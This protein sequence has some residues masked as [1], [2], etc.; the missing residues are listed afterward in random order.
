MNGKLVRKSFGRGSSA[1]ADAVA[2]VEKARTIRRTGEGVLPTTAKRPVLTTV[3]VAVLGDADAITVGKL[4]DEFL[5]YVRAHPEEYR[6]Q[7]NPPKRIAEIKKVFG[8]RNAKKLK[9]PE[10][11]DW[12]DEIQ[13]DREL[14]NA[15]INKMRGSF[16]MIYKHGKRKDLVSVN[17]A[18][19]VP[20]RDV[21]QGIE[22]FLSADEEK[23]LRKVLQRHIDT[24]DPVEHPELR[25]QAIHRLL[26]FEVSLKSGMRRSEQYNLQWGEVDFD[27]RIMR[28][29]KT[30]NGKPRNAFI[31]D[32]VA[33]ALKQ[34]R[35][36]DL[37][38]RDRSGS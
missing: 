10:V 22:R 1:R 31:I 23:R 9:C 29:R 35:E 38:R 33:A 28:L 8:E 14:A 34:L 6:D 17:P 27:R 32:D 21:G 3:E 7:V 11:E 19:D 4:C 2:W 16:S 5:Q 26:E 13:E 37:V 12:L 30:K 25:K 36:L 15:T 20:L 18:A 24:H